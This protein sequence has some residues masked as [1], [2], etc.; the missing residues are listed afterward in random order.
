MSCDLEVTNE[1]ALCLEKMYAIGWFARDVTAAMLVVK[2]KIISPPL[3]TKLYFYVNSSR[4]NSIVL[5]PN[6][7][8]LSSGCKPR[9]AVCFI[10]KLRENTVVGGFAV[11]FPFLVRK[12]RDSAARK[13]NRG[14]QNK[15]PPKIRHLPRLKR[16]EFQPCHCG[17]S[18]PYLSLYVL[19]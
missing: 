8:A 10:C 7:T 6:M 14:R 15:I 11:C 4:K 13:L 1:S 3:G 18:L 2:N 16:G 17:P 19:K 5:T 12:V 9:R